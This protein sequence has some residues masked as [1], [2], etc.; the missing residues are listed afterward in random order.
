MIQNTRVQF[1]AIVILSIVAAYVAVPLP[2][3][4][5]IPFLSEARI[6]P[7]IDLAG[8]AELHYKVLFPV[9]FKDDRKQATRVAT[10]VI[11]RR[12]EALQLKEPKIHSQGDDGIVIQLAGVDAEG[13]REVKRIIRVLG[14]LELYAAAPQDLQERFDKDGVVPDG[15]KIVRKADGASLLIQERPVIEGRRII[16]AEPHRE[17]EVFGVRWV[18]SF[19]LD[20]EGAKDFDEAARRLYAQQP[21]GRIVIV[22][23]GRVE[24]APVV[25]SPSF[26]GR[27]Q[28]SGA[29]DEQEARELSI[30]LRSGS[31]PA[32][33]GSYR[34]GADRPK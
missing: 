23:D 25:Q 17:A 3:K 14:N 18:T 29:K 24:S 26:H 10:D 32:P 1:I 5:R 27:G 6:H 21:R 34:E 33:I 15:Y 9:G 19:E 20:A 8:G 7:G 4:P 28:I 2:N 16:H 31:L 13:L 12:L 22:L 11:R 30:I